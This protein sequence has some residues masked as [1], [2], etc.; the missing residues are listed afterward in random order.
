VSNRHKNK[1]ELNLEKYKS[2]PRIRD[3]PLTVLIGRIQA[4]I[5]KCVQRNQRM[6]V[7]ISGLSSPVLRKVRDILRRHGFSWRFASNNSLDDTLV[8][9][10][11]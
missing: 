1:M 5:D 3:D 10:T 6:E 4:E 11:E 2:L 7:D 8:F 9:Y